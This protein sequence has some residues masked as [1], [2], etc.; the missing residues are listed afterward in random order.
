M[1]TAHDKKP[2]D[3]EKGTNSLG[4]LPERPNLTKS[5]V[6]FLHY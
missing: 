1:R 6:E 3:K 4:L 2:K 5:Q